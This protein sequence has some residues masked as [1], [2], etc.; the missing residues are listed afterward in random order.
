MLI[1]TRQRAL[2]DTLAFPAWLTDHTEH[3]LD[4]NAAF[5]ARIEPTRGQVVGRN[6]ADM[7]PVEE[8]Q[9]AVTATQRVLS[10]GLS[11]TQEREDPD[12]GR[13]YE[14]ERSPFCDVPGTVRGL[15]GLRLDISERVESLRTLRF[16]AEFLGI[17]TELA[18]DLINRPVD[19]P[20]AGI[21]DAVARA[22]SFVAVD[23]CD[24][25]LH[26]HGSGTM[27]NTHEWCA[28]GVAPE[29]DN[30]SDIPMAV[31]EEWIG[32]HARGQPYEI[33]LVPALPLGSNER[34]AL[35]PQGIVSR[36]TVPLL[37]EDQLVGFVRFDAVHEAKRWS[38]DERRLLRVVHR[39]WR[40]R[41][42][43]PS[44]DPPP[45]AGSAGT[46]ATST[47]P[48]DDAAPSDA[49]RVFDPSVR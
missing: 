32:T 35:E 1:L 31:S 33:P 38:P 8:Q 3:Y 6:A 25:F 45:G 43:A 16:Q 21:E 20:D 36:Y 4:V 9:D 18:V 11:E 44:G 48:A 29:I 37:A 5:L 17:L 15:I 46:G 12:T 24:V 41:R 22:G 14:I 7:L 42:E 23:R 26:D 40:P 47:D 13:T 28:P 27:R 39:A 10:T 34:Q 19:D 49:P 30:L 2:L